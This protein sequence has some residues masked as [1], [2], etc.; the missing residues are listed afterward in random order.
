[1]NG[2]KV[3]YD[4]QLLESFSCRVKF[5]FEAMSTH[6]KKRIVEDRSA[7]SIDEKHVLNDRSIRQ[8][9]RHAVVSLVN[10]LL[11]PL[12]AMNHL[13]FT[14]YIHPHSTALCLRALRALNRAQPTP[15]FRPRDRSIE[16]LRCCVCFLHFRVYF[17]N[18]VSRQRCGVLL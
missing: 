2:T 3:I 13:R 7:R 11:H 5:R 18:Q 9:E 15:P 10:G 14:L 17:F 1:M 12:S 16:I 8:A 4:K 6:E